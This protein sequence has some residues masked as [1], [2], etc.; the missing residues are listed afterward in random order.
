M[1]R[2]KPVV[3]ESQ[4]DAADADPCRQRDGQPAQAQGESDSASRE[5]AIRLVAYALYEARNGADGSA[6]DDWLAAEARIAQIASAG[7]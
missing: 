7:D 4:Q 6:E 5:E 2:K 1:A 3:H